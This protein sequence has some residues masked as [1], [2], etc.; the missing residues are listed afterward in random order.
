MQTATCILSEMLQAEQRIHTK[1]AFEILKL[2]KQ[3]RNS[4]D[5]VPLRLTGKL[6][7]TEIIE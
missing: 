2:L 6:Y 1:A 4:L 3:T 5:K 7:N